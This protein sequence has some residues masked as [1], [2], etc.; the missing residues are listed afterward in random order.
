MLI[1]KEL[2]EALSHVNVLTDSVSKNIS[3]AT[4]QVKQL[5]D[6]VK[7]LTAMGVLAFGLISVVAM[8][9]LLIASRKRL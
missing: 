3:Y 4:N 1:G 9:A 8:S 5:S 2:K 7:A 6:D